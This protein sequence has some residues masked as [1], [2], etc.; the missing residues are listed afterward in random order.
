MLNVGDNSGMDNIANANMKLKIAFTNGGAAA[1]II[2]NVQTTHIDRPAKLRELRLEEDYRN[3]VIVTELKKCDGYFLAASKEEVREFEVRGGADVPIAGAVGATGGGNLGF[4][5]SVHG[6][7]SVMKYSAESD[8]FYRQFIYPLLERESIAHKWATH[9]FIQ[10][11][12]GTLR[13]CMANQQYEAYER[14]GRRGDDSPNFRFRDRSNFR[15]R[16]LSAGA[17]RG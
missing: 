16:C 7:P 11:R 15:R 10:A 8:T 13:L 6:G 17:W 2:H 12:T 9:S 5:F 14:R 1:L 4:R 3:K